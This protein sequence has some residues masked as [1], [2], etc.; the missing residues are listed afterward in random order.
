MNRPLTHS[1]RRRA[2]QQKIRTA[3]ATRRVAVTDIP[4]SAQP[5]IPPPPALASTQKLTV[6]N[7]K[8][9]KESSSNVTTTTSSSQRAE[10][11]AAEDEPMEEE[12]QDELIVSLNTQVV[13][14]QYYKG[15]KPFNSQVLNFSTPI[16]GLVGPGEE[17]ILAVRDF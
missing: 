11:D 16:L 9:R 7:P 4:V 14:I 15:V 5:V 17:V 6:V 3:L 12:V 13:G 10:I 1:F 8:K 2:D